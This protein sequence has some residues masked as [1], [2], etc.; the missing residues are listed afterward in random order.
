M[1]NQDDD[2]DLLSMFKN[3]LDDSEDDDI[4]IGSSSKK[5]RLN[6]CQRCYCWNFNFWSKYLHLVT[7]VTPEVFTLNYCCFTTCANT[8]SVECKHF[9]QMTCKILVQANLLNKN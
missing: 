3:E 5:G 2:D 8:S 4:M 1:K 6:K 7:K 9:D